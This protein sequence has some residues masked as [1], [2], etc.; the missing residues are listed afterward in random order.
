MSLEVGNAVSEA[1]ERITTQAALVLLGL[2]TLT[3]VLQTAAT[4]DIVREFIEALRD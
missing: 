3:S 2:Y 4:Q 1:F